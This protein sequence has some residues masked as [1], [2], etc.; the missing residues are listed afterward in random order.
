[1]LGFV[2]GGGGFGGFWLFH[3]ARNDGGRLFGFEGGF[4]LFGFFS[5]GFE[6]VDATFGVYNL[7][8]AGEEGVGGGGDLSFD[9]GVLFAVGPF[10]GFF[11][12]GGRPREE[13]EVG[14]FVGEDDGAIIF[15]VEGFFHIGGII[16][17]WV[18]RS[19]EWIASLRS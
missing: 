1:M 18:R 10:D 15:G 6:A 16:S 7:F 8:F 14:L 5:A 13:G 12:L 19:K 3:F 9:K 11:G 4:E 2:C 17:D